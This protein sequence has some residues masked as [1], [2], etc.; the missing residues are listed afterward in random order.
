M[1]MRAKKRN[2]NHDT[3]IYENPL[4]LSHGA[5]ILFL[6]HVQINRLCSVE[7]VIFL[8]FTMF[9]REKTYRIQKS[10][11]ITSTKNKFL[12]AFHD[13]QH[14]QN[15]NCC[16]FKYL[17]WLMCFGFLLLL[18][19]FWWR[20]LTFS[21]A[22]CDRVTARIAHY[23]FIIFIILLFHYRVSL[24]LVCNKWSSY[25]RNVLLCCGCVLNI[26]IINS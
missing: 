2:N 17:S 1:P 22:W 15:K 3:T 7:K 10:Y 6:S 25:F 8:F 18:L 19:L 9:W 12:C 23:I 5:V 11:R 4:P 26:K 16:I 20:K 24:L 14:Q 13:Q 21:H